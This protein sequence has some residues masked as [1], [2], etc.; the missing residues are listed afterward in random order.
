M[1]KLDYKNWYDAKFLHT[2]PNNSRSDKRII[3]DSSKR[4]IPGKSEV[5]AFYKAS[6]KRRARS[7]MLYTS[8]VASKD[9]TDSTFRS[10]ACKGNILKMLKF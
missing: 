3:A 9:R 6:T 4:F 8:P 2:D 1:K 10:A 5:H 7:S